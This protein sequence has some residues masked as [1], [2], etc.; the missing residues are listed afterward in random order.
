M[1]V[2][3]KWLHTERPDL[4]EPSALLDRLPH[5]VGEAKRP[6]V[7]DAPWEYSFSGWIAQQTGLPS[8]GVATAGA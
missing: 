4:V 5:R 7:L 2:P 1:I 6:A 8:A 3:M